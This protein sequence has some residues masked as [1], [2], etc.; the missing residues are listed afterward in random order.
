MNDAETLPLLN[1]SMRGSCKSFTP[2]DIHDHHST[3]SE[4]VASQLYDKLVDKAQ[5]MSVHSKS[6][7]SKAEKLSKKS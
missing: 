5:I 7:A 4:I 1:N 3:K 6:F 2:A